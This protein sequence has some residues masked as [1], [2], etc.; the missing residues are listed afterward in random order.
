MSYDKLVNK[1]D[2]KIQKKNTRIDKTEVIELNSGNVA[3]ISVVN[4][5]DTQKLSI[6]D[7]KSSTLLNWYPQ[8]VKKHKKSSSTTSMRSDTTEPVKIPI[9][10]QVKK[11][12]K[13]CPILNLRDV[14]NI[15][16]EINSSYLA[17]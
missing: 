4:R 6:K 14:Q 12:P 1:S 3:A 9:Q 16:Y 7:S 11:I 5:S 2:Q 10:K 13:C 15:N 17:D 8:N